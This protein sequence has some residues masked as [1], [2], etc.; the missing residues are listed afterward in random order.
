MFTMIS[1][2]SSFGLKALW[3]GVSGYLFEILKVKLLL[4]L[5]LQYAKKH[6]EYVDFF[7]Y[8]IYMC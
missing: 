6:Q 2:P 5:Y 7:V 1:I 3:H 4:N 8:S